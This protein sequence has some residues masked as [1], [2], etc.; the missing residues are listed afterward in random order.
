M[1]DRAIDDDIIEEDFRL[2]QIKSNNFIQ[3]RP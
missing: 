1:Y 2:F 3:F